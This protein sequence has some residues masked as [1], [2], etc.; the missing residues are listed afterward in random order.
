MKIPASATIEKVYSGLRG[1]MCG[2]KGKYT[3]PEESAR[4]VKII[5]GKLERNPATRVEEGFGEMIAYF[6]TDTRTIACYY[7]LKEKRT[8]DCN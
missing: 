2:C 7:K 4:S 8:V 6:D 5:V 1:C 3:T